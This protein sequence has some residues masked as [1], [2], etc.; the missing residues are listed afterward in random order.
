[1]EWH[2]R[3]KGINSRYLTNVSKDTTLLDLCDSLVCLRYTVPTD[4]TRLFVSCAGTY[5]S[6]ELYVVKEVDEDNHVRYEFTDKEGRIVLT[7]SIMVMK[8]WMTHTIY[9]IYSEIYG[10]FFLRC[11]LPIF[12]QVLLRIVLLFY[13]IMLSCINTIPVT[14]VLGKTAWLRVGGISV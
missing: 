5:A 10:L 14:V 8:E 1:M 13:P 11:V 2:N 3:G 6:G 12:I 7:R 9:M 4:R